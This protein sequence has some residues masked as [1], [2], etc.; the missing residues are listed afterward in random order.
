MI[1]TSIQM[2]ASGEKG[3]LSRK[4]RV[5]VNDA[6]FT[7]RLKMS[8]AFNY[9]QE[10]AALHAEKLGVGFDEL[11]KKHGAIWI[12]VRMRVD[13]N[14]L[15][16]WNEEVY[17]ETWPQKPSKVHFE[18][19]YVMK[20]DAGQ[21]IAKGISHWVLL[22]R[23]TKQFLRPAV[24]EDAFPNSP[25]PSPIEEPL[26]KLKVPGELAGVYQRVIGCSDIDQNGHMNNSKYLDFIMDCF[27]MKE[28]R[29]HEV[30]SIQVNYVEE[31]FPGDVLMMKKKILSGEVGEKPGEIYIEGERI[32]D[33]SVVFRS[34]IKFIKRDD[35][36]KK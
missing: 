8:A 29:S 30:S 18:R 32:Q 27:S 11:N 14:R 24:L 6:D 13:F 31:T 23:E 15:P 20:D 4:Y 16:K 21:V 3:K 9:F 1:G 33:S 5:L 19:D 10:I 28:L 12:L 17:L 34:K 2:E 22:Q 7:Q 36:E 26:G 25:Y 35:M